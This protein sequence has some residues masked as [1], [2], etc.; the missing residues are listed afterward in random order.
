MEQSTVAGPVYVIILCITPIYSNNSNDQYS[1]WVYA[2][3]VNYTIV[4]VH[5][6]YICFLAFAHNIVFKLHPCL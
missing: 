6:L 5:A 3:Y 2:M 4:F 1:Y